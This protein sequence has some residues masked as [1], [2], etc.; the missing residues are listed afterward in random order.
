VSLEIPDL[1]PG[2]P[3]ATRIVVGEV[4][5]RFRAQPQRPADT[6]HVDADHAGALAAPE[7]RDRQARQ[8]THRTIR[9]VADRG[10]DLAAKRFEVDLIAAVD[11][12]TLADLIVCRLGFRGAEEEALEHQVEH[13]PVLARLGEGRGQRL[14]E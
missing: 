7:R 13:A 6:L 1:L 2:Q 11:R 5:L 14:L 9:P 4:R 8:V 3:G 12:I 10:G